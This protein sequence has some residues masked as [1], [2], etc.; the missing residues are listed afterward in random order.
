MQPS[1][2][3][4]RGLGVPLLLLARRV[5]LVAPARTTLGVWLVVPCP[6]AA[7]GVFARAL[8][9][10]SWRLFTA[11]RALCVLCAVSVA[12]WPLF[13][14]ARAVCGTRVLLVASL[15]SPPPPYCFCVFFPC[16]CL[17]DAFLFSLL[18]FLF[19]KKKEE[20]RKRGARTP[21]A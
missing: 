12:T 4:T 10:A 20:K 1:R 11:A 8:S 15:G 18:L 21:K 2:A 6:S 16:C 7:L 13:T 9:G 14:G 17:L 3:R 19:F 5:G